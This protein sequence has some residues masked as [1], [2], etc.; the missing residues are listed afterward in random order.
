ME[1]NIRERVL[2]A[3]SE[4]S[5]EIMENQDKDLLMNDIID[6]FDI[7]AIMVELEEAFDIEIEAE[8]VTPD[9]FRTVDSIVEVV[10]RVIEG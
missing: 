4:V 2:E 3:I 5:D 1:K 9:N 10:K 8:D 6:S 7:V